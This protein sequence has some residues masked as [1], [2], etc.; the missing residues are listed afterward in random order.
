MRPA[1]ERPARGGVDR[2][3]DHL[4]SPRGAG[5]PAGGMGEGPGQ[6]PDQDQ[7]SVQQADTDFLRRY[8][9][10]IDEARG[11]EPRP[12][13]WSNSSPGG[14]R[15]SSGH[16]PRPAE[17]SIGRRRNA[18]SWPGWKPK[19]LTQTDADGDQQRLDIREVVEKTDRIIADKQAEIER[20]SKSCRP[21]QQP[22][23]PGRG[24]GGRGRS[25][26]TRTPVVREERENL[27]RLKQQWEQR[28]REAEIETSIER[29]SI[30]RQLERNSKPDQG[31]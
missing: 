14:R 11:L 4:A 18:A 1:G 31:V 2:L 30:A 23:K 26:W 19:R 25:S 5:E 27:R 22:R 28:M 10:V 21:V 29:A 24:C 8:E 12:R 6:A 13:S 15:R 3:S 9:K 17:C 7:G 16:A 20:S